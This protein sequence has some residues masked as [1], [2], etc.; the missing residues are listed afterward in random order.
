MIKQ[1][2]KGFIAAL[3]AG[4]LSFSLG[5]GALADQV[6]PYPTA[7]Q[8][9]SF[10]D[11]AKKDLTAATNYFIDQPDLPGWSTTASDGKLELWYTGFTPASV[12]GGI[13]FA[14]Q[15]GSWFMEINANL[16]DTQLYQD[17]ATNDGALYQWSFW[18][19]GR[20]GT[21]TA[22]M[23]LGP[24]GA[25][26]TDDAQPAA[27]GYEGTVGG[28]FTGTTGP[29]YLTAQRGAWV[30]HMGYYVAEADVTRFA[31]YAY[32]SAYTNK[33]VGN[34]VDNA[35]WTPIAF[36]TAQTL[37]VGDAAP[38]DSTLVDNLAAGYTIDPQNVPDMTAVG[39]YKITVQV[40]DAA[41]GV[42]GSIVSTVQVLAA[43]TTGESLPQTGN[44]HS[45]LLW[46]AVL[47]CGGATAAL[48]SLALSRNKH[49]TRRRYAPK[50]GG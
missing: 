36:P 38:N 7:L 26:T 2:L 22:M 5:G 25:L 23:L 34:L 9:G 50:H 4:L 6:I 16:P 21:D 14:A 12:P 1:V 17:L 20:T 13:S 31:L 24:Q 11:N 48:V 42:V 3:A 10:E 47:V 8:N 40:L 19:R 37:H 41:S 44:Q 35:A 27:P 28:G 15:D 33:T 49:G 18:H 46:V 43:G 32:D 39:T 30:Q 29:T 45:V